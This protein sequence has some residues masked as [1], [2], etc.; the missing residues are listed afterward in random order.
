MSAFRKALDL[1]QRFERAAN[2][3]CGQTVVYAGA[4]QQQL[5]N[6]D[7]GFAFDA[8]VFIADNYAEKLPYVAKDP[9]IIKQ[10][11]VMEVGECFRVLHGEPYNNKGVL[12]VLQIGT[13]RKPYRMPVPADIPQKFIHPHPCL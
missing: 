10:L 6:D 8:Y 1:L 7:Q 5:E 9:K 12:T 11:K 2:Q 3:H 4:S 13:D